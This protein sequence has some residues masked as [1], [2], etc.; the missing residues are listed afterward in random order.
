MHASREVLPASLVL[1]VGHALHETA[2]ME[3]E[4]DPGEHF[5]Q[6]VEPNAEVTV[7]GSHGVHM[8]LVEWPYVPAWQGAHCPDDVA[9]V[10]IEY[11]PAAHSWHSP[12]AEIE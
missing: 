3:A 2:A 7:P 11:E 1:P 8:V 4:N 6:V 12:D 10:V 5:V 9:P